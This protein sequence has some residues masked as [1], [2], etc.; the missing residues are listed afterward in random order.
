M[1]VK[2]SYNVGINL[3]YFDQFLYLP[4]SYDFNGKRVNI[5]PIS[6]Y[7]L[8]HGFFRSSRDIEHCP[9]DIL[10]HPAN[11]AA[12]LSPAPN[13][14]GMTIYSKVA[15]LHA[16]KRIAIKDKY[17]GFMCPEYTSLIMSTDTT[18]T[19]RNLSNIAPLMKAPGDKLLVRADY[20]SLGN[21]LFPVDKHKEIPFT[22]DTITVDGGVSWARECLAGRGGDDGLERIISRGWHFVAAIPN[23]KAEYRLLVKPD[24][25]IDCCP[26]NRVLNE[27]GL[28][29]GRVAY[30][31]EGQNEQ[32]R[33]FNEENFPALREHIVLIRDLVRN[34]LLWK[35]LP[36]GSFDLFVTTTGEWG[37]FE[38]S[39][40]FA[41]NGMQNDLREQTLMEMV[42]YYLTK[43]IGE[44]DELGDLEADEKELSF[45]PN[46]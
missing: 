17:T 39:T 28:P 25:T 24:G 40:Q 20:G 12:T 2:Q 29:I 1:N 4:R 13:I 42:D 11:Y 43:Y 14:V 10:F 37:F 46:I 22:I 8:E 45:H 5:L 6:D 3:Q 41:L 44:D 16:F 21:S 36:F 30:T 27:F 34:E 38:F 26:R 18:A 35:Y 33:N 32:Y 9:F 19:K 23:I 7:D 31:A 15:Q